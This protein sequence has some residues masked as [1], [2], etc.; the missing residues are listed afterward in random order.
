MNQQ[1]YSYRLPNLIKTK[2]TIGSV[3][4][5]MILLFFHQGHSQQVQLRGSVAVHHSKYQTSKVIYVQNTYLSALFTKP[6]LRDVRLLFA[7]E[8]VD[9]DP[10]MAMKIEASKQGLE[11]VNTRH[12]H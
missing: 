2:L 8:F 10:G 7:L 4:G 5:I 9:L 11:I 1:I 3:L 12:L 6:A